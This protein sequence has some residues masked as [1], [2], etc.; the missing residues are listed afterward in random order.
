MDNEVRETRVN[1]PASAS[2]RRWLTIFFVTV[3]WTCFLASLFLPAVE[4]PS[5]TH[6]GECEPGWTVFYLTVVPVSWFLVFP[7]AYFLVNLQ[8]LVMLIIPLVP[9]HWQSVWFFAKSPLLKAGS[10]PYCCSLAI[11]AAWIAPFWVQTV[12]LGWLLWS[13]AITFAAA[14]RIRSAFFVGPRLLAN[15]K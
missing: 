1:E 10:S 15:D 13:L 8:L 3:A 5:D 4:P 6:T 12:C 11:I 14:E 2:N 9:S 7:F